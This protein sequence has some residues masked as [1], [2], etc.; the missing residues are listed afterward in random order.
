MGPVG[1]DDTERHLHK[2]QFTEI[3]LVPKKDHPDNTSVRRSS[4]I[5]QFT[6]FIGPHGL[7]R[8]CGRFR[9]VA[10]VEFDT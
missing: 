9:R 10:E 8:S 6:Q 2:L 1:L 5:A 3:Q 7:I 4:R